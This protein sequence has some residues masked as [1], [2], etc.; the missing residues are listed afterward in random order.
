M[1]SGLR[2]W[3]YWSTAF[4]W[5]TVWFLIRVGLFISVFYAFSIK[6]SMKY[7]KKTFFKQY[8]D[9]AGTVFILI[10]AM[11]LYGWTAIPS[12]YWFSFGFTSAPKGF[13]LIVMF[14]IITGLILRNN[15]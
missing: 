9:S 13:T 6:V 11:T 15:L 4:V 10:L 8:T 14:H 3:M 12:T 1:L 2:P 5:D 7:K